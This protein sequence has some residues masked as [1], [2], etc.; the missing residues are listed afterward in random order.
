MDS[1][2]DM[3]DV[4]AFTGGAAEAAEVASAV[5]VADP[6]IEAP[7]LDKKRRRGGWY[8]KLVAHYLKRNVARR[9]AVVTDATPHARATAAIRRACFKSAVSGAVTGMVSTGAT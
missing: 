2:N 9:E 3:G 8:P 6:V 5:G 1:A 4:A 7:L